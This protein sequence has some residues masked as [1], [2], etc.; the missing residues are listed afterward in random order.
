MSDLPDKLRANVEKSLQLNST[1]KIIKFLNS[2]NMSLT[3]KE[4]EMLDRFDVIDNL[5]RNGK[6][7]AYIQRVM[8]QKFGITDRQTNRDIIDTKEIYGSIR[9][10]N[11]NYYMAFLLESMIG[12]IK[13]AREEGPSRLKE[14]VLAEKNLFSLLESIEDK[15]T[16]AGVKNIIINITSDPESIGLKPVDDL[17][18]KIA[19]YLREKKTI[20]VDAETID[21]IEDE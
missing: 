11:K 10:I 9:T 6:S 16:A 5:L 3:Q 13:T 14:K 4:H 12:S 21:P 17:E 2:G 7:P 20:Q 15:E 18:K 8:K 19:K 1:E